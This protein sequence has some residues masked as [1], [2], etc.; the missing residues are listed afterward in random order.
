MKLLVLDGNSILNRAFYGIKL[1][2]TKNGEYTNAIYGFL[3]MMSKILTDVEPDSVAIAFDLKKPTFRHLKYDGYKA[4]R[5]GMPNELASQLP[6]IRELLQKLGYHIVECEGYE[7]DDIL[8]TLAKKCEETNNECVLATGDR[9]SLQLISPNVNVRLITTKNVVTYNEDKIK[10]EYGVSPKQLIDIK[11]SQGDTSDNIPGI[12]GIGQKGASELIIKY[13]SIDYIYENLDSIEVKPAMY[14]KLVEGKESAYLSKFLGEI[15]KEAPIDTNLNSY[16]PTNGDKAGAL[17]IMTRLEL[18][19]LI[20]K[21]GLGNE[22][23]TDNEDSKK[24][25]KIYNTEMFNLDKVLDNKTVAILLSNDKIALAN[26][27]NVYISDDVI[28]VLRALFTSNCKKITHNIKEIF[29]LLDKENVQPD[30]NVFDIELAGYLLNP[31]AS[32]YD[33]PRLVQ[34]YGLEKI[35][36][37]FNNLDYNDDEKQLLTQVAQLFGE[38]GSRQHRHRQTAGEGGFIQGFSHLRVVN[39]LHYT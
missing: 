28:N 36:V 27:N 11:A 34:E 33:I 10:E 15:S 38:A 24:P 9:D 12:K 4:N 1:L 7:A 22:T 16:I 3:T 19:S 8:G 39:F 20:E 21:W 5:H 32:S 13:G 18:F 37:N 25:E 26:C 29:S 2:T 23:V 6:I 31:S 30:L 35:H 17:Q 14:K